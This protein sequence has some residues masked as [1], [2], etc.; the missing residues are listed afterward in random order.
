M[1]QTLVPSPVAVPVLPENAPF[2]A[3]QRAW[4]NGFFAGLLGMDAAAARVAE[5]PAAATA[6]PAAAEEDG[7]WHDPALPMGERLKLAEGKPLRSVL[8]AAMAQLDCGACGYVCRT[9]SEAIA[10]GREKNLTLCSPGGKETWKKLKEIVA[11]SRKEMDAPETALAAVARTQTNGKRPS[12]DRKNPFPARFLRNVRL[13]K[14]GSSKDT[15]HIALDLEGSGISY[16]VGDSLGVYPENCPELVQSIIEAL[17]AS[18]SEKVPG[19]DGDEVSLRDGLLSHRAITRPSDDLLA[20]LAAR[21][22]RAAGAEGERLRA[23]SEGDSTEESPAER[24][25]L[26]LLVEFPAARPGPAELVASLSALQPRLYSISSSIKAHPDE[27]HLTVRA[28]RYRSNGRERKGVASTFLADR[29]EPGH[30]VRVFVQPSHGFRLPASPDTPM[31]MVGPGTGIAPFR[32]FLEER[33][34]VGAR[35]R[36]WLFFG[37]REREH[38]F[39]YREELEE[40]SRQGILTRFDTAFSRDGDRKDYVQHRM[41]ERAAE[42]W[43]WLQEGATFHVCGDA[44]RMARDVDE[45]LKRIVAAEGA[46]SGDAAK[47]YVDDLARAKRYQRDVY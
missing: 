18:G 47:A 35:G 45:A 31:I 9:Y 3:A 1:S 16:E 8:M 5:P 33:R 15:R 24:D 23:L 13:N 2:T 25:L 27:V 30:R 22:A 14:A 32:A 46:L 7:P 42:I 36:N 26:D 44:S 41:E 19:A 17:G 20:L 37:D 12:H 43:A 21:A 34:A 40:F 29:V 39:L 11:A 38:D 6:A 4:L 10:A 28:V